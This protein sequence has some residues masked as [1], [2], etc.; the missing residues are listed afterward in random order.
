MVYP[1][2]N[3]M[4]EGDWERFTLE[5]GNGERVALICGRPE[6]SSIC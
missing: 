2:Q 6:A 4:E 5:E 1:V 3:T